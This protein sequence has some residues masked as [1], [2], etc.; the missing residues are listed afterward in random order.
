MGRRTRPDRVN[1]KSYHAKICIDL[2]LEFKSRLK[3]R[4]DT[5]QYYCNKIKL[6]DYNM[7]QFRDYIITEVD[8]KDI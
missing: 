6:S 8:E 1:M 5:E 3:L 7:Q 2:I 4:L